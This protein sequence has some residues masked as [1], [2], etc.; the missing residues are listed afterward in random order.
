MA[1]SRHF[2]W[3]SRFF[4]GVLLLSQTILSQ[5]PAV[6][7]EARVLGVGLLFSQLQPTCGPRVQCADATSFPGSFQSHPDGI[8]PLML[9]F[10]F[11]GERENLSCARSFHTEPLT[12]ASS[13]GVVLHKRVHVL[14]Y[15][16]KPKALLDAEKINDLQ[17]PMAE[18]PFDR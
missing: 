13:S 2:I 5:P 6:L 15:F 7:E 3:S 18:T 12:K 4:S 17:N 10:T 14:G 9:V 8:Q 16:T 1:T 11:S